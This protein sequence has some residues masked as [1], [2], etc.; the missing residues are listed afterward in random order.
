MDLICFSIR[1]KGV[2]NFLRRIW[3][4]FTRFSLSDAR[5][6]RSLYAMMDALRSYSAT[7]TFFIPAVVLRRHASLIAEVAHGGAEI[8]IHGYVHTDYRLLSAA[9]QYHQTHRAIAVF[10]ETGIPYRGFRNPYLGWTDESLGVFASLGFTYESGEAILHDVIDRDRLQPCLRKGYEKSLRLYQ[11]MPCT[12]YTL[13]PHCEGSLLR[14][15]TS[16][17]DD[18]MLFDRLRITDAAEIGRIWSRVMQNVYDKGGLYVLNLHPER[19]TLCKDA[20]DALLRDACGHALPVWVASLLEIAQWWE[21]RRRCG[22]TVVPDG[23]GRWRVEA[24][25]SARLTLLSRH[26]AVED[27]RTSPW[28]GSEVRVDGRCCVVRA[29]RS[30][31]VGLS[32]R[33]APVVGE[34]LREQGYATVCC[35]AEEA[36]RCALY[37][38]QPEGLGTT[39]AEQIRRRSAL[40]DRVEQIAT[41]LVHLGSWPDGHR[42]ALAI[43]GDID[44]VTIQDFFLRVG[45]VR[46][47]A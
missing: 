31:C 35:P 11:A 25:G 39:R 12:A 27:R 46:Q 28:W 3:T 4:V 42:A 24:H 47:S 16:L 37:V 22:L 23:L 15:P 32:P 13:R 10:H 36:A 34:F 30:P 7:P 14:L 5:T 45:E 19:G 38:D 43:S 26:L 33:T 41:P 21:E 44:S 1:T 6:R 40:V 2:H 18:E 20:L 8:G 29:A 17:P 9:E